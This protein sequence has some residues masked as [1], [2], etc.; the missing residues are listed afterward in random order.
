MKKRGVSRG[1]KSFKRANIEKLV[2]EDF[3]TGEYCKD[4]AKKYGVEVHVIYN[5]L[6]EAGLKR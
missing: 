5:I 2:I 1:Q 3:K 4:L 6:D